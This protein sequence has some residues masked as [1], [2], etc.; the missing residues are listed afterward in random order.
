[1]GGSV[2]LSADG[3]LA[4]TG[5]P[6]LAGAARPLLD[7]VGWVAR[8]IEIGLS[9]AVRMATANPARLL[10][11]PRGALRVGAVGDVVTLRVDAATGRLAV[12]TTVVRGVV[13]HPSWTA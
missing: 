5:A 4:L 10:G 7:C 8:H 6:L 13:V 9:D 2:E 11:L 1:V 12:D 3:R